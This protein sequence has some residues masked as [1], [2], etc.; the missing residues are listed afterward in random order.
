MQLELKRLQ[1]EVGITFIIVTHDQEEALVMA[2]R[3][4]VLKDGR[5]LQCDTPQEIYERPAD[6]FVADFIGS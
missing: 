6:R 1:H 3:M 4:A 2:D 5:L